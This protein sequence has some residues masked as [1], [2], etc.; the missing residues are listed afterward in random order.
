MEIL[1]LQYITNADGE[2]LSVIVPIAIW[3]EI[4]SELETAYLL[5]SPVMRKRLLEAKER[6]DGCI[7]LEEVRARLGL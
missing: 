5:S 4:S 3:R 1:E 6:T 2:Q 7:S